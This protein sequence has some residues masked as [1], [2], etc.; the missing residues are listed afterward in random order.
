VW[1]AGAHVQ[2]TDTVK[3][4]VV[5]LDSTVSFDK[6]II[7]VLAPVTITFALCVTYVPF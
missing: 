1:V 3:L 5:T 7:D 4:L 6:H 2:F